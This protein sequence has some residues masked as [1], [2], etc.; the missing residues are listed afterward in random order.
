VT[1][2]RLTRVPARQA[3]SDFIRQFRERT[4][5]ES[6]G[7]PQ[8]RRRRTKGLRREEVAALA[9]VGLT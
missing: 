9:G 3:L 1:S 2:D 4:S 8:V 6:V 7:L 5:P